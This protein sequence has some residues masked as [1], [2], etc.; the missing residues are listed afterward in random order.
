MGAG[1]EDEAEAPSVR[2]PRVDLELPVRF[3]FMGEERV[4]ALVNVSMGGAF[5]RLDEPPPVQTVL[6]L[7]LQSPVGPP[8]FFHATVVRVGEALDQRLMASSGCAVH[9]LN[10]SPESEGRLA[11]LLKQL[12]WKP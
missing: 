2:E 5:I 6:A 1:P 9:F 11:Y 12:A 4:G 3:Y 8:I 10:L 7:A